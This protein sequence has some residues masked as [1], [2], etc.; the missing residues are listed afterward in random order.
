MLLKALES[1]IIG[2][3]IAAIPGPIF[4]ELVRRTLS[5]GLADGILLVLGEFSGNFVLLLVVFFGVF[6]FFIADAG[7]IHN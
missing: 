1:L 4:F 6:H 5:K 7:L 3:S 2:V